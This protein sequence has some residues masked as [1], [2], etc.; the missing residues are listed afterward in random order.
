MLAGDQASFSTS[1][2]NARDQSLYDTQSTQ[3]SQPELQFACLYTKYKT[4]KRKVWQDGRLVLHASRARL[5]SATPVAGSTDPVLDECEITAM[6]RQNLA[7]S[8]EVQLETEKFLIQ[9]EGPWIPP[10]RG[11]QPHNTTT[12][13]AM[14][15]NMQKLIQRKFQRP[16]TYVPPPP[17]ARANRLQVVLGK[18]RRPLQPGELER[19]H[20][21]VSGGGGSEASTQPPLAPCGAPPMTYHQQQEH[22]RAVP[23]QQSQTHPAARDFTTPVDTRL[24]GFT[25]INQRQNLAPLAPDAPGNALL[26]P[27]PYFITPP[28]NHGGGYRGPNAVPLVQNAALARQQNAPRHSRPGSLKFVSNEFSSTGY[29][30][31]DEEGEEDSEQPAAGY[32][33]F[34]PPQQAT[35]TSTEDTV[36]DSEGPSPFSLVGGSSSILLPPDE[37]SNPHPQYQQAVTV[38][39]AQQSTLGRPSAPSRPRTTNELMA[40]FGA[41]PIGRSNMSTNGEKENSNNG[42]AQAAPGPISKPVGV[43][44]APS[45]KADNAVKFCLPSPTSSTSSSDDDEQE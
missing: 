12:S 25:G 36:D 27:D 44:T 42:M 22:Q 10:S 32:R 40:L 13:N 38:S 28:P 20:Y 21:G 4:Q 43:S 16:A 23:P 15:S 30:G 1:G 18:R 17:A 39:A 3:P 19:M 11:S 45:A 6:Q 33:P 2:T 29:Y 31:L 7:Q 41:A 34:P 9:I 37:E 26:A 5:F 24:E 14:S 35:R 8:H